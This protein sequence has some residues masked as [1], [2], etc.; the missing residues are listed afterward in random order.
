MRLFGWFRFPA[1]PR[2]LAP[3]RR[4]RIRRH[5][6]ARR[7]APGWQIPAA[8]CLEK[9]RMLS[10][11]LSV[12]NPAPLAEGDF[13]TTNMPFVITRSGNT[14]ADVLVSYNTV[15][16][17]ALAGADYV[18]TSGTLEFAP[19]VTTQTVNVPVIGNTIRQFDRQFSLQLGS[20]I[21]LPPAAKFSSAQSFAAGSVPN[22][23]TIADINGDGLKDLIA[24][25]QGSGTVS[26]LLNTTAPGAATPS[27]AAQQTFGV[28]AGARAVVASDLNGDGRVDLVVAST[29]AS[30]V[31]VLMNTTTAGSATASFAPQQ[32]FDCGLVQALQGVLT[33]SDINGDGKTDLVVTNTSSNAVSVLMNTTAPGAATANFAAPQTIA[34]G[35]EPYAVIAADVNGDGL[36]DLIATN[37]TS[38]SVSVMLNTT[39]PGAATASFAA[40]QSF[41]TGKQ[42]YGVTAADI[43]GD[44]RADLIV[45]NSQSNS[46]SVLLNTTAAGAAQPSFAAQQTFASGTFPTAVTSSDFNG[47]GRPDLVIS[48]YNATAEVVLVNQTQVGSATATFGPATS[49]AAGGKARAA[50]AADLNGDGAV[51]LVVAN[52][53]AGSLSVVLNTTPLPLSS[54]VNFPQQASFA[55]P[56]QSDSLKAADLNGDGRPDLVATS[57]NQNGVAVLMNTMAPGASIPTF[58][59]Q[60]L[61]GT[62]LGA[63]SVT[64]TDVNGDGRPDL[65]VANQNSNTLSVLLNTTAPGAAVPTFSAQ[66]LFAAGGSVPIELTAADVN[67]D[68]RPDLLVTCYSSGSVAVLLNTT[69]AG[70]AVPSFAAAKLIPANLFPTDVKAADVNGDGLNDLVV[71]SYGSNK[72][73]VMLNTTAPGAAVPTFSSPTAFSTDTHPWGVAL[74]DFNGDGKKDILTANKGSDDVSVLFNTTAPG[75][76]TPSFAAQQVFAVGQQPGSAAAVDVN[77]DGKPDVVVSG[78]NTT[79]I[80]LLFNTTTPGSATAAF[81]APN[82]YAAGED[83]RSAAAVDLNGDGFIDLIA[84]NRSPQTATVLIGGPVPIPING[85]PATATIQDDDLPVTITAVSGTTPQSALIGGTFGTNLAALVKNAAGHAVSNVGVSFSASVAGPSGTFENM[86]S[87]KIVTDGSGVATAPVFVANQTDGAYSVTATATAGANPSTS[88]SLTNTVVTPAPHFTSAKSAVFT[89]GMTGTFQV[90]ATG[91]PGIILS[92]SA[93][94]VLPGGVTFNSATGILTGQP[95]AGSAGDYILHFTAAN[96]TVPDATQTFTLKVTP[97]FS[98]AGEYATFSE[99]GNPGLASIDQSGNALTLKGFVTIGGNITDATHFLMNGV[100]V[101]TYGNG[102]IKFLAGTFAGQTWTKLVLPTNFTNPAGAPVHVSQN[103]TT[104]TFTDKYGI[105]APG[106]W[107]NATQLSAWGEVVT[108]GSG[109][110]AGQLLWADGTVWSEAIVVGGT[111]SGGGPVQ[112]ASVPN[113]IQVM[114][115]VN[116]KGLATYAITNGTTML[117]IID[118]LG[119]MSVAKFFNT[120]QA[121]DDRY[122]GDMLTVSGL[123]LVWQDGSIWTPTYSSAPALAVGNYT[124]SVGISTHVVVNNTSSVM[125]VDGAGTISVGTFINGTQV[126]VPQYP[127]DL[128]TFGAGNITWQDGGVWTVTST[129]PVKITATDQNGGISHLRFQSATILIGLDG[130]LNGVVG[131]RVNNQIEWANGT[132]WTNF[133]DDL[134][135]A[136]FKMGTGFP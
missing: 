35:T 38:N 66:Q 89:V 94:D 52:T 68:G 7:A 134:L 127:N 125:F 32:L 45:G 47:D 79:A 84:D 112:L 118:S 19:G 109:N 3:R 74:A 24:D 2:V 12:S 135:H 114:R 63:C 20:A 53:Q 41:A 21:E 88:F 98:F 43:N 117:G 81:A 77:N 25:N 133:N 72:V 76:V 124:N 55:I 58:A 8:V 96:G 5:A 56:S 27:F 83:S 131:T 34:A 99:S 120:T 42:P 31:A 115:Y 129:P 50:A 26:V 104:V 82:S 78:N 64:I 39:A 101:A 93:G 69:A 70:A 46:I 62:G 6:F 87:V 92:E 28:P 119:T 15:D 86:S 136:L 37:A 30:S 123:K 59:A 23:V 33:V 49:L 102:S 113:Q 17:T 65:A 103:G 105:Q 90:K 85:S 18:A 36:T 60:Q 16:G 108:I 61:F 130:P 11:T 128:A 29:S 111:Q 67:G 116:G 40:P 22:G 91:A 57:I 51:D 54:N 75:A 13:G 80:T 121:T 71:S 73:S 110:S 126:S 122:P 95:A 97:P 106:T 10:V 1:V 9:R 14:T 100:N 132:F 107:V 44:G 48:C 4:N